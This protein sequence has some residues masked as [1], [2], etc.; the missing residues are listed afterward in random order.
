VKLLGLLII[1][2]GPKS[3]QQKKKA[4]YYLP[5]W[6]REPSNW[7]MPFSQPSSS[8]SWPYL[9]DL[10]YGYPAEL[11]L[12]TLP[13]FQRLISWFR[14]SG[15]DFIVAIWTVPVSN[16]DSVLNS[17]SP[18]QSG[19]I[20]IIVRVMS[21]YSFDAVFMATRP[22]EETAA[23]MMLLHWHFG[24]ICRLCGIRCSSLLFKLPNLAQVTQF[25][26]L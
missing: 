22:T 18:F 10:G 3:K 20:H 23:L 17:A 9:S 13:E 11:S 26:S 12:R 24:H 16:S 2:V 5:S 4:K 6:S 21:H 1:A 14:G 15:C 25:A 19:P 8:T 7:Q